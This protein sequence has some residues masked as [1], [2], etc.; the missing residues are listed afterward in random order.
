MNTAAQAPKK[1]IKSLVGRSHCLFSAGPQPVY[2]HEE[3]AAFFRQ[4]LLYLTNPLEVRWAVLHRNTM[5]AVFL[6]IYL[7]VNSVIPG[8]VRKKLLVFRL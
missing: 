2:C 1:V 3:G 4:T 5:H 8:K 6:C 7:Y